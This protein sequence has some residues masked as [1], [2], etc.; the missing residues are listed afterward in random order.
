MAT[1]TAATMCIRVPAGVTIRIHMTVVIHIMCAEL[2]IQI[3]RITHILIPTGR[4]LPNEGAV[5]SY[6]SGGGNER[7]IARHNGQADY[8]WLR[9]P[10]V[11]ND[12]HAYWVYQDGDVGD[13]GNYAW[14]ASGGR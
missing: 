10:Y 13:Y 4:N 9:S 8:W 2:D 7:R 6:F 12:R 14:T 3:G 1:P 11:Y 5:F